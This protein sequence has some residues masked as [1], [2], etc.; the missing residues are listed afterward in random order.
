MERALITLAIM[1]PDKNNGRKKL[2]KVLLLP[3]LGA[4]PTMIFGSKITVLCIS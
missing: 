2:L 1:H 4:N 3:N